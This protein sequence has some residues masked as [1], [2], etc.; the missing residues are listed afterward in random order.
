MPPSS[1]NPQM[2][3]K[4]DASGSSSM[5]D[6]HQMFHMGS[7]AGSWG[8]RKEKPGERSAARL[9][10]SGLG[11]E[12]SEVEVKAFFSRFYSTV[13]DVHLDRSGSGGHGYVSFRFGGERDKAVI[14]LQGRELHGY[15]L[16]LSKAAA[17]RPSAV[18]A[19]AP[20]PRGAPLTDEQIFSMLL[21]RET[22]RAHRDFRAADD[23]RNS[24]RHNGVL[25]D[26]AARTWRTD[27]GRGGL[28]PPAQ[29]GPAWSGGPAGASTFGASTFGAST[30]GA[31]TFGVSKFDEARTL[32]ATLGDESCGTKALARILAPFHV[33]SVT[34]TRDGYAACLFPD[35]Q[36]AAAALAVSHYTPTGN[37]I[38]LTAARDLR[39][40]REAAA[41]A[42][43]AYAGQA[44]YGG[45]GTPMKVGW[46]AE[47]SAQYGC[48][49]Y[50]N[51]TRGLTQWEPP[52]EATGTGAASGGGLVDYSDDEE[53]EEGGPIPAGA[54]QAAGAAPSA[55]D[56]TSSLP[57]PEFFY[58]D[59]TGSVQGPFAL[60]LVLEWVAR[61]ALPADTPACAVGADEF[62]PLRDLP[63]FSA[64]F[65]KLAQHATPGTAATANSS[66]ADQPRGVPTQPRA[67]VETAGA[68][69]A[70]EPVGSAAADS[71]GAEAGQP[72]RSAA[73]HNQET[74]HETDQVP[75]QE[76][77]Q[78]PNQET[79][80]GATGGKAEASG[81]A[82]GQGKPQA[83]RAGAEAAG[84][85]EVKVGAKEAKAAQEMAAGGVKAKAAA[86]ARAKAAAE[87]KAKAAA[88]AKAKAAAQAKVAA[89]AKAKAA[90][91]ANVAAKASATAAAEAKVAA[92]AKAKAAA[93]AKVAAEAKAKAALAAG[94]AK[95]AVE[96]KGADGEAEPAASSAL[97]PKRGQG[98]KARPVTEAAPAAAVPAETSAAVAPAGAPAESKAAK[99]G[100]ATAPAPAAAQN[101]EAAPEA[102][103]EAADERKA[104][105]M[106]KPAKR[107][108]GGQGAAQEA[109]FIDVPTAPQD[110]AGGGDAGQAASE[111]SL[112]AL[113]VA[114]LRAR[115]D[116]L[117][118]DASG[119]KD[120]LIKRIL[121]AQ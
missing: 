3:S 107:G 56:D 11:P 111:K 89:E 86:E 52:A 34:S 7:G 32:C 69:A 22:A 99:R 71:P 8:Q 5:G 60:P 42:V 102:I 2:S 50:T 88:E 83:G 94:Q 61:G 77:D 96:A 68:P 28:L 110:P 82:V 37:R 30:F 76:T 84:A 74:D 33:E 40:S 49:F 39:L 97:K 78:V 121:Q 24:L 53:E 65:D 105:E 106:T 6:V 26:E 31:S 10:L 21:R 29:P 17:A 92:E 9:R 98:A 63:E 1:G 12:V 46:I 119:V 27:D 109:V 62:A 108:R 70:Q 79:I 59:V 54:P 81:A 58:G 104:D 114:E 18:A 36:A 57:A 14:E 47:W 80:S 64:A 91:E 13:E 103:A 118:L 44:A 48:Y 87:A 66:A 19:A 73:A 55:A 16:S 85:A 113:K 45:F 90:A 41:H 43:T 116:S 112:K 15:P 117:G 75:N 23:L 38:A 101:E 100:R 115:C 120:V 4:V 72:D 93:E 35:S 25:I 20:P 51:P 95:T 67:G